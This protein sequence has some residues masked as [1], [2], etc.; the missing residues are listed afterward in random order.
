MKGVTIF[1]SFYRVE[2]AT[3]VVFRINGVAFVSPI[4]YTA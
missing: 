2:N 4:L 3:M 1:I